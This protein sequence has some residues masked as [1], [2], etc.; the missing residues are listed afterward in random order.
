MSDS[1]TRR[2]LELNAPL[3]GSGFL[4]L[5]VG[6]VLWLCGAAVAAF[7]VGK[8]AKKWIDELDESPSEIARKRMHQF[9]VAASAGSRAWRDQSL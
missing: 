9:K 3:L 2:K 1:T 7:A 5:W 8:A 6:G 4:L